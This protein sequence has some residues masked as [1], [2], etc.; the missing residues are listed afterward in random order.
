MR[1]SRSPSTA[2]T[3][4]RRRPACLFARRGADQPVP[5]G[6]DHCLAAADA[7][8]EQPGARAGRGEICCER[9]DGGYSWSKP[10]PCDGA[11]PTTHRVSSSGRMYRLTGRPRPPPTSSSGGYPLRQF[12]RSLITSKG[13]G[14]T[15]KVPGMSDFIRS[16]GLLPLRCTADW[17]RPDVCVVHLAGALDTWP[18]HPSSPSI[19]R[20]RPP[21]PR[22]V[23][24]GPGPGD[25]PRRER[26]RTD[27]E[28]TARLQPDSRPTPLGRCNGQPAGGAR[29]GADWSAA[30][31]RR[32]DG[33][34]ALLDGIDRR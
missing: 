15:P 3:G 1:R 19:C 10:C 34:H 21:L 5:Q 22:G 14:P 32:D 13:D 25:A 6:G 9:G 4:G 7:V 27:R 29:S 18:P 8:A 16:E 12:L 17:P 2:R 28:R 23:D 26:S 31:P 33:V 20:S 24:I 11:G 30:A